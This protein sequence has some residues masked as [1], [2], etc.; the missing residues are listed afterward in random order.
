MMIITFW[1]II[2]SILLFLCGMLIGEMAAERH[3]ANAEISTLKPTWWV[4]EKLK[5]VHRKQ[6]VEARKEV[7]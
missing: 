5:A 6:V 1:G 2:S 7:S 3:C 4:I